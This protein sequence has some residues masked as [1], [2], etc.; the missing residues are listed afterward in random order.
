MESVFNWACRYPYRAMY[1]RGRSVDLASRCP[2]GKGQHRWTLGA[3]LRLRRCNHS[4]GTIGSVL[5]DG[6]DRLLAELSIDAAGSEASA[7]EIHPA[8]CLRRRRR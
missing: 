4:S 3:D 7:A 2:V 5:E 8:V 6:L 1:E